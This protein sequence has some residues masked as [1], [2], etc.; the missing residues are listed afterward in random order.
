M[1]AVESFFNMIRNNTEGMRSMSDK[2]KLL[3][4]FLAATLLLCCLAA[5]FLG[6]SKPAV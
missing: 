1:L 6:H 4:L 2:R 5:Y 3:S